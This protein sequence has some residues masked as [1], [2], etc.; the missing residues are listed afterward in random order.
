MNFNSSLNTTNNQ[1]KNNS[2]NFTQSLFNPSSTSTGGNTSLFNTNKP[3][4]SILTNNTTNNKL[5]GSTT[6][7]GNSLFKTNTNNN[8]LINTNNPNNSLFPSTS[9]GNTGNNIFNNNINPNMNTGTNN[10][11]NYDPKINYNNISL[12][13]NNY[14]KYEKVSNVFEESQKTALYRVD[15]ILNNNDILLESSEIVIK[16]LESNKQLLL[17][18][19]NDIIKM[20]KTIANTHKNCKFIV[21]NIIKEIRYQG[22]LAD[23]AKKCY[24]ILE[25]HPNIKLSTP[26]DYFESNVNDLEF[27]YE[28]FKKQIND[29]E[30]LII[31]SSEVS[32]NN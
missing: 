13:N 7:T 3:V 5:F 29:L 32:N 16:N 1:P 17:K 30:S 19:C 26:N 27:K 10:Q 20:S 25:N 11:I 8:F 18:E 28:N 14:L 23:K 4:N 2:T 22:E 15:N 9:T 12:S 6:T 31:L 24:N 21:D